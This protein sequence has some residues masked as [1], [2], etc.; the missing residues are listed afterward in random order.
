MNVFG[1]R[2]EAVWGASERKLGRGFAGVPLDNVGVQDGL[3]ALNSLQ[4]TPDQ[5]GDLSARIGGRD[6][7]LVPTAARIVPSPRRPTT[8]VSIPCAF[9]VDMCLPDPVKSPYWP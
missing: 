4:I 8:C 2:P 3:I 5:F 6:I 1:P 7:D 9:P